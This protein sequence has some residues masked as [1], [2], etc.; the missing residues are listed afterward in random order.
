MS[1][2]P[3]FLAQAGII[4]LLQ[5]FVGSPV[6]A[7]TL[8]HSV[9]TAL[10]QHPSIDA[11]VANRDAYIQ[12]KKEQWADHFP[13]LNLRGTGGRQ[14][15]DNST[16]RGL[17]VTR[18]STY[19]YLWEGSATLS[20]P[21]FDGF[22]TFNR[23]DAAQMRRD[24][25]NFNITDV[26]ETLAMRTTM[27]Y[28]D[29]LR[30]QASLTRIA[31]HLRK[32]S[33]YQTRIQSMV[34]EGAADESMI[35][36]ARDIKAQL[37]STR[38]DIEGQLKS[39]IAEYTELVGVAPEGVLE[40]PVPAL[41]LLPDNPDDA[42]VA[43]KRTHPAIKAASYTEK[44]LSYDAEAEEQFYFPDVTGE[45]SYLKRDQREEI[46]GESVDAKAVVRLNWD[47]S[48]AGAQV[49]R[50]RKA[51]HRE[52]ESRAQRSETERAIERDI[53]ISYEEMRT[54]KEQLDIQRDRVKI[55]EDLFETYEA[56]FE[57]ARINLLQLLQS[58]NALFNAR[59]GY[60]NGEFRYLATQFAVLASMGKLQEALD[61]VSAK[62]NGE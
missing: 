42:L 25:A 8:S 32:I 41:D 44:A 37:Q 52:H 34:D 49:A 18:D 33:D 15:G 36:Q 4:T 14:F 10:N 22:E 2:K 23:V 21:I 6:G 3:T 38:T 54:A 53:R 61:V 43:A 39:A 56:Q 19:S 46:G 30:T 26:R 27:V 48:I 59:L 35:V 5:L 47:L 1:F 13:S 51:R 50:V 57:V 24:S 17:Q 20:Q 55:N 45:L 16:S 58:D 31:A 7:E 60:L 12:E 28:L 29:I 40:R 62:N 11:A 9:A